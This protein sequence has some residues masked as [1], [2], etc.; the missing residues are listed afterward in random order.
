MSTPRQPNAAR[1]SRART[2][3]SD[4]SD[5]VRFLTKP[6]KKG[7]PRTEEE[8]E[9][10]VRATTE[11]ATIARVIDVWQRVSKAR[12]SLLRLRPLSGLPDATSGL[13][14]HPLVELATECVQRLMPIV[15]APMFPTND[16]AWNRGATAVDAFVALDVEGV[17]GRL[18]RAPLNRYLPTLRSEPQ[19][20]VFMADR[21][22]ALGK[23][24]PRLSTTEMEALFQLTG[25][26][27]ASEDFIDDPAGLANRREN[28]KK[29]IKKVRSLSP[30]LLR[31]LR[32]N[33]GAEER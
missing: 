20:A 9:F 16:A 19:M 8:V 1:P 23:A 2:R 12:E 25:L 4:E 5:A 18:D 28:I 10:L 21:A 33:R 15:E 31:A 32:S 6:Q 7:E 24:G 17:V 26:R 11:G 30:G 3:F 22:C 27:P 14:I 29:L 13:G